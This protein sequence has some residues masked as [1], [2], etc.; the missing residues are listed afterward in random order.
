MAKTEKETP[1]VETNLGLPREQLAD[2]L[3]QMYEIRFFEEKVAELLKM[4]IIKGA[5]HLYAGEEAVA[6]GAISAITEDDVIASTH[7]GHGHCGAI[8]VKHAHTEAERQEHWNKMMAE[9]MGKATGYC[10]GRGGS[11]HIADVAKGNL[12][13]TGIVG[14]NIPIGTGA[15]LAEKL[16]GTKN[17][18]LCFFGDG[19]SN[20]GAFHESLNM[21]ASL[22]GGLPVVYICENNLYGMSVA[23]HKKSVEDAGRASK[24]ENVA[25][26]ASAYGI[27][28]YIVNGMDVLAVRDV[29]LRAVE[30]ARQGGGP[31]LIEAKTYRWFGHS[32]SDQRIYRT[33]EEE[34]EWKSKCPIENFRIRLQKEAGF[35]E[36]ELNKIR[37]TAFETIEKATEFAM[38]SPY[39][40]VSE[41]YDDVYVPLD[42][43]RWEA[44]KA[45]EKPLAEKIKAIEAEIRAFTR[46]QSGGAPKAALPKLNKE[47]VAQFEEKYGIPI[48]TYVQAIVDAQREEM[49]RDERVFIMGEDVG[50]YGGA[51][52]AT[53]G[54]YA[55]FGPNRVIDTAISEAAIAGAAAAAAMRGMRP[56]A[57][58]MYIDFATIAS[59]QIVHNMA[60]N[61][62]MFGGKT[63]VP[64]VLRTEG[65]VGRCI[66]AHHS[67]SLEAWFVHI[68]GLYVVMPSTPYDAKGLLKASIRDDNPVIFIEHKVLYSGVMGPVPTE[69]YIIPLGVADIKREG[70]DATVV[71]YSRMLHF[72]LDAACELE[73][74]G[75]SIEVVDPRTLK[76]LDVETIANSVRK[77]GRL[78]TVSEGYPAC[79]VG[80]TI[81]RQVSE[82]RFA[83]GTLCFDYLD[84]PPV[85]LAGKDVP[86]PMS[87]PLEDAVVPS[88]DDIVQAVKSVL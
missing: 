19:A 14:G 15:A 26:R 39:P 38:N 8:G 74:E 47:A 42:I 55:E 6:V 88:R 13:S 44:E 28:G 62:Y 64:C 67:E 86:I 45:R 2:F 37:D 27:P 7:R 81:V 83:D 79:G 58:I 61:R 23:F 77:T 41:L 46:Q 50:L 17:V 34:A 3:R 80:E 87:E 10:K 71:A 9:L 51:Y 30:R 65:G 70:T 49:K 25:D 5:S 85:V 76:P 82:F 75:I 72:A 11:M 63:K 78:I 40:D 4:G 53:R 43:E 24:I 60:Y 36:E 69:D 73:K 16:K 54:L 22:L 56:I 68:P 21:G 33:K 52:A 57:E 84:A 48:I 35:T 66:A 32:I 1:V 31:T 12:G 59:D 20:T 18:V 29:V